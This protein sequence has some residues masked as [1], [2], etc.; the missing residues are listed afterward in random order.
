V[1]WIFGLCAIAVALV[2]STTLD[3]SQKFDQPAS[4]ARSP[5]NANYEIDVRLE[6]GDR[7]LHGR[8]RIRWRNISANPTSELQFHLYWNAWRNAESTWLRERRLGGN[9]YDATAGC[10]GF[11]RHQGASRHAGPELRP[12][13]ERSLHCA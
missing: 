12:R 2:L 10:M 4:G 9:A 5:R 3:G 6:P 8:E 1:R 11:D 13:L 7:T